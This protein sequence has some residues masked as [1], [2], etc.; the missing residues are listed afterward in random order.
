MNRQNLSAQLNREVNKSFQEGIRFTTFSQ[1][2]WTF[3][4]HNTS[5][6]REINKESWRPVLSPLSNGHG[7][8]HYFCVAGNWR[9]FQI[10]LPLKA[11]VRFIGTHFISSA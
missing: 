8:E 7:E 5:G 3:E 9:Q 1:K 4:R 2:I 10:M 6:W 11:A